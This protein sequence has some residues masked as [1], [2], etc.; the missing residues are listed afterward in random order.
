MLPLTFADP[1][2]YDKVSGHDTISLL[3]L[4]DISPDKPLTLRVH[5][6][7][8]DID[9]PVLHSFNANQLGWF[10]AGSALN[11]MKSQNA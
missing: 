8:G 9:L 5:K 6:E 3:G 11:M 7:G 10:R 2:D 1:A 4:T